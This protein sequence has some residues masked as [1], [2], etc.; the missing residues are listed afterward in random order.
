M[1]NS[2]NSRSADNQQVSK[3]IKDDYFAGFVDGEGCFYVGFSKRLDLPIPWQIITEF[4]V[5]QNPGSRNVLEAFRDRLDCGY[6]KPNHAKS[7]TDR[8]WILIVK[9]RNDLQNKVIPFFDKHF[10]H[11]AKQQ[12]LIIFK[13]VLKIIA[14]KHHL[15]RTGFSQI[16]NLVF[17]TKRITN[18]RYTKEILLSF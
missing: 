2:E 16:V 1:K 17:S 15:K 11:S 3:K 10:L 13:K 5:S 6:L 9:D 7:A 4:H 12:D 14:S 18:K 8:S